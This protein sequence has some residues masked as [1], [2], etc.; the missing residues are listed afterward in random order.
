M[1]SKSKFDRKRVHVYY[2]LLF[3]LV[4]VVAVVII[5]N[6]KAPVVDEGGNIVG[7][8]G[9]NRNRFSVNRPRAATATYQRGGGTSAVG[10]LCSNDNQCSSGLCGRNRYGDYVCENVGSNPHGADCVSHRECSSS[11]PRCTSSSGGVANCR[12]LYIN[13]PYA[14]NCWCDSLAALNS[15][16]EVNSDCSNGICEGGTVTVV[17]RDCNTQGTPC[18]EGYCETPIGDNHGNCV[19]TT[20]GPRLCQSSSTSGQ[21]GNSCTTHEQCGSE[22]YCFQGSTCTPKKPDGRSNNCQT[23][24]ECVTPHCHFDPGAERGF[25]GYP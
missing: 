20:T 7:E 11:S 4:A 15:P 19:Y 21:S 6:Q 22:R 14:L 1:K 18:S 2:L 3:V 24:D 16:C 10:S 12:N 25:C 13:D 8:A 9:A 23:P 5:L 17:G